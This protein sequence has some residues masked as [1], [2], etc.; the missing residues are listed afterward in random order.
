VKGSIDGL[1]G[2]SAFI[3][4]GQKLSFWDYFVPISVVSNLNYFETL[5]II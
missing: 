3:E 2:D 5:L 4:G 1:K